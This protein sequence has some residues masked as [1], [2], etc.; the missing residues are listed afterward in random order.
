[1]KSPSS[2]AQISLEVKVNVP[3]VSKIT[4]CDNNA[5]VNRWSLCALRLHWV[6]MH[7]VCDHGV[8]QLLDVKIPHDLF[9]RHQELPGTQG[10]WVRE[11]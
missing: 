11:M 1:M 4:E 5:P 3:E 9:E 6:N 10:D 8:Q 7:V 2:G